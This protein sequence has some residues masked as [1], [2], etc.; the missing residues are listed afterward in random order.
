[1]SAYDKVLNIPVAVKF[2]RPSRSSSVEARARFIGEAQTTAS[3]S[4]PGIVRIFEVGQIDQLP[5]MTTARVDGGTL[6]KLLAENRRHFSHRQ[7]VW[8]TAQI[9]DAVQFAH[10]MAT[11]HRDLKPANILLERCEPALSEGLGVRPILTDFGLAKRIRD[12][13]SPPNLTED[14]RTIG[15]TRYMSPEQVR[16]EAN[17]LGTGT[18]IF[19]LGIVLYEL[20]LGSVPFSGRNQHE[21]RSSIE[22]AEVVRPRTLDR[23]IPKDLEAIVLKCL[24]QEPENRYATAHE[25]WLD[26]NRFLEGKPVEARRSTFFSRAVSTVRRHPIPVTLGLVTVL[27]I[28][29]ALVL[30]SYSLNTVKQSLAIQKASNERVAESLRAAEQSRAS[31][32]TAL[33]NVVKLIGDTSDKIIAGQSINIREVLP[34][35]E[36]TNEYL[37][38]YLETHPDDIEIS[39]RLSVIQ[40]YLSIIY[41]RTEQWERS[42]QTRRDCIELLTR[43]VQLKPDNSRFQFDLFFSKLVMVDLTASSM[44]SLPSQS[45]EPLRYATEAVKEIEVLCE[46]FPNNMDYCDARA[47]AKVTRG[48]LLCENDSTIEEGLSQLNSGIQD[49]LR[50]WSEHK[51]EPRLAKHAIMGNHH[52]AIHLIKTGRNEEALVAVQTAVN[53]HNETKAS[54]GQG[55]ASLAQSNMILANYRDVLIANSRL[56]EAVSVIEELNEIHKAIMQQEVGKLWVMLKLSNLATGWSLLNQLGDSQKASHFIQLLQSELQDL[57][58]DSEYRDEMLEL[59]KRMAPTIDMEALTTSR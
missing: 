27:A 15:T 19:S 18:D 28:V 21:V 14:G 34:T 55:M 20:L 16:G 38:E 8:I 58:T 44:A 53:L 4:H 24:Q 39:H 41:W 31:Q 40:H 59:I 17:R 5:F 13:D 42:I 45:A 57:Q 33:R 36:S 48:H 32:R 54:L 10:S 25:L 49:S 2:L 50:S 35:M 23:S 11:L 52:R 51:D 43:L 1:L 29:A 7:A 30:L 56:E 47:A 3:L 12:D 37:K 22:R 26:L 46:R 9:A 6:A